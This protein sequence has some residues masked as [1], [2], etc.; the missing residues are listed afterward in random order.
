MEVQ[1][2]FSDKNKQQK[3]KKKKKKAVKKFYRSKYIISM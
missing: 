2:Q 3:M 1:T